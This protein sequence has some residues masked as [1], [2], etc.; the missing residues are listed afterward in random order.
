LTQSDRRHSVAATLSVLPTLVVVALQFR[1]IW[2]SGTDSVSDVVYTY[3]PVLAA[4]AALLLALFVAWKAPNRRDARAL[5]WMLISFAVNSTLITWPFESGWRAA[6]GVRIATAIWPALWVH[7]TMVF[8]DDLTLDHIA[9]LRASDAQPGLRSRLR[10][11]LLD[12]QAYVLA[13]PWTLYAFSA[14]WIAQFAFSAWT[15]DM[16]YRPNV[17]LDGALG[18][19]PGQVD[20]LLASLSR[21][22]GH[23][24]VILTVLASATF[25]WT[26]YRTAAEA[27]RRRILWVVLAMV[28][29]AWWVLGFQAL[30]LTTRFT[31]SIVLFNIASVYATLYFPVLWLTGLTGLGASVLIS[32]AFDLRPVVH[33]TGVYSALFVILTFVFASIEEFVEGQLA[34]RFGIDGAG[35]WISA[36]FLALAFGPLRTRLEKVAARVRGVI[37]DGSPPEA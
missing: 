6:V 19:G 31:G 17:A 2:R 5:V 32:G 23:V 12:I 14:A 27:A 37:M 24:L 11:N 18:P 16:E 36:G 22:F 21:A 29:T 8:H 30:S 4:A 9:R 10:A 1:A 15:G 28:V 26:S 35:T 7:F 20:A 34:Q 13:R 25:L 3:S 33:K